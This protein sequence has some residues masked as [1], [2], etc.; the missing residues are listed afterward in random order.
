MGDIVDIYF[1]LN[2]FTK[3]RRDSAQDSLY[4]IHQTATGHRRAR[5]LQRHELLRY[6]NPVS[7]RLSGHSGVWCPTSDRLQR[8]LSAAHDVSYT[9]ASLSG[10]KRSPE[11]YEN[12]TWQSVSTTNGRVDED[13]D[14]Y[15]QSI[16]RSTKTQRG[17][18]CPQRMEK[19]MKTVI[20]IDSRYRGV[21][22]PNV[23]ISVHNEWKVDEDGNQ[24][25]QSIQRSTKTQLFNQCSQ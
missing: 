1:D 4:S 13:G 11:E 10:I 3:K 24:Y 22:K 19:W 14:Q 25:R 5:R 16:Q 9:Q 6:R 7:H 2:I 12:P 17:N 15:R 18:Q 8:N 21:R 23:A 20:S